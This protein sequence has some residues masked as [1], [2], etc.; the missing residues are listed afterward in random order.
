MHMKIHELRNVSC[1]II[2]SIFQRQIIGPAI[3][4]VHKLAQT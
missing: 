2:I 3:P 4:P 1:P